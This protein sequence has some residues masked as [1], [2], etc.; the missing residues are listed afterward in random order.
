[1]KPLSFCFL[2]IG[3]IGW[4]CAAQT[5]TPGTALDPVLQSR[6]VGAG[7]D[8]P[9]LELTPLTA[10]P[11]R[12]LVL[13]CAETVPALNVST[14]SFSALTGATQAEIY[15]PLRS[16]RFYLVEPEL[17]SENRFVRAAQTI[18]EPRPVRLGKVRIASPVITA[19]KKKNPLCL[20][21]PLVF[22]VSF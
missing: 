12:K 21:N 16:D 3:W 10:P 22:Q 5:N 8:V 19:I 9:R 2:F 13:E 6:S 1:M 20:L 18:W 4:S 17:R 14:Q 11:D 7:V 15:G